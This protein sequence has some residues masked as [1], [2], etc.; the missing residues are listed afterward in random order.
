MRNKVSSWILIIVLMMGMSGCAFPLC[1]ISGQ[2]IR[3]GNQEYDNII[4]NM[5]YRYKLYY[6]ECTDRNT[7]VIASRGAAVKIMPFC[8][9]IKKQV[10]NVKER[11]AVERYNRINGCVTS[12]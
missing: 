4:V 3:E 2:V 12:L 5:G 9:W 1:A 11:K 8:E 10:N 7:Q 6:K